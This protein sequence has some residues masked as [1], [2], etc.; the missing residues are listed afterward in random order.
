[1]TSRAVTI[2]SRSREGQDNTR[3]QAL[4]L[5]LK[6]FALTMLEAES[7]SE[8]RREKLLPRLLPE[9]L[10]VCLERGYNRTE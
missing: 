9:L 1:M 8:S 10:G 3:T 7:P 5:Q 2:L 6:A 4:W